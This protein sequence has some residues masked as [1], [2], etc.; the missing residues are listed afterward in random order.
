METEPWKSKHGNRNMEANTQKYLHISR[1]QLNQ[2]TF[3]AIKYKKYGF[4]F[5][6]INS[7][8]RKFSRTNNISPCFTHPF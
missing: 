5:K 2:L 1:T 3:K 6:P 7:N 8:E 4:A